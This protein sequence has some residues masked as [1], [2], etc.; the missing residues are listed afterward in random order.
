ME[1]QAKGTENSGSVSDGSKAAISA[2]VP[3][4]NEEAVL[5]NCVRS[6][7][8]Q[9]EVDEIFIVNDRSTDGTA[10]EARGLAAEIARV[11]L[12]ETQ[13]V[14]AGW[15][16][17]NNA[18]W[19]G[20]KAARS[21]W[22]LFTDADAEL[23]PG[24]A[25]RALQVAHDSDAVLI[26]FSPEQI[27]ERWYE[28]SLIPFVYCRLAKYFSYRDVNDPASTVAAA[29]GQ[30]LMIRRE[31]YEQIGG[32]ASIAG[33]VLEDVALARRVKSAGQRI[34]FGPGKGIVRARMYRS[35][36]AMWQGW[37]KN[38]YLLIGASRGAVYRELLSIVPW[39]PAILLLLGTR[40]PF[41]LLAGI[42][43]LVARHAAYGQALASNRFSVSLI[44][45]YVPAVVLYTG[46]LWSSYQAH[47]NGK[48]EWKGREVS[49]GNSGR[50]NS[51]TR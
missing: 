3:A 34:W 20:A 40:F 16:G 27:T 46:V 23:A 17:K 2:I 13:E 28:K 32:H 33:E 15:L 19:I 11:Q 8:L 26:S 51:Q 14:P 1:N 9:P 31:V 4:R 50:L 29:N 10:N 44:L 6:L 21:D 37:Q 36:D 24:A 38:L 47:R 7:A 18:V 49:V 5:A 22:L 35:F 12:L 39:I 45:Y 41:A 43:L 48:I 25:A 30:F 42:G